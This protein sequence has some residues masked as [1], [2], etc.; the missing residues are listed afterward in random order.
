VNFFFLDM[1]RPISPPPRSEPHQPHLLSKLSIQV[2]HTLPKKLS[3]FNSEPTTAAASCEIEEETEGR[4]PDHAADHAAETAA[5]ASS[6]VVV[7]L[8][9]EKKPSITALDWA[10]SE[11]CKEGDEITVLAYLQHIMSPSA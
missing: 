8:D 2:R 6:K 1:L 10:M 5:A 4:A 7:V 3:T 9:A 11:V